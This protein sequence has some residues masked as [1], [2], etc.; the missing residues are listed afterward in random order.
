[1]CVIWQLI[2]SLSKQILQDFSSANVEDMSASFLLK[3]QPLL[4]SSP[5]LIFPNR[6]PTGH[7]KVVPSSIL[8][9]AVWTAGPNQ[10]CIT[11]VLTISHPT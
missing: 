10:C 5:G 1:M 8:V 4:T 9:V 11:R 7:V 3:V 6:G 2:F